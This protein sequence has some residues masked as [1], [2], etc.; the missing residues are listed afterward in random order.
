VLACFLLGSL[1][2][3]ESGGDMFL[4]NVEQLFPNRTMLQSRGTTLFIVTAVR[5]SNLTKCV[6]SDVASL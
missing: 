6:R 1:F 3:S 5:A 4:R 2:D